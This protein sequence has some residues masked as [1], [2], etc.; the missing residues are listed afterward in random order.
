MGAADLNSASKVAVYSD[1]YYVL[2]AADGNHPDVALFKLNNKV[3]TTSTVRPIRLP[4]GSQESWTFENWSILLQGY[5]GTT[6][7]KYGSFKVVPNYQCNF[8]DN[9]ICSVGEASSAVLSESGD[10]GKKI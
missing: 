2:N 9:L 8:N 1:A 5:A 7:L 6:C 4:S 10:S 3:A